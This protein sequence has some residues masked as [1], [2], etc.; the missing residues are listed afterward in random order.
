MGENFK[1]LFWIAS[2]SVIT[3]LILVFSSTSFGLSRG[4][5]WL[6][7]QYDAADYEIYMLVLEKSIDKFQILGGI[8]FGVGL[9]LAILT[10]FVFLLA[11]TPVEQPIVKNLMEIKEEL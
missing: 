10:Y 9:L 4:Q 2:F 5:A 7:K 8:L 1:A 3:G 11:A 6:E